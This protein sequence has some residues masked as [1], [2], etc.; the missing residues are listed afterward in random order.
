MGKGYYK[1][2]KRCFTWFGY[3]SYHGLDWLNLFLIW[4]DKFDLQVFRQIPM[5]D[6]VVFKR[7]KKNSVFERGVWESFIQQAKFILKI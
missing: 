7:L 5:L 1:A 4:I 3:L 6:T 2:Q